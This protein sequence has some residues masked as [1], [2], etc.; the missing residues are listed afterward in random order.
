MQSDNLLANQSTNNFSKSGTNNNDNNQINNNKHHYHQLYSSPSKSQGN[1]VF[2]PTSNNF[3]FSNP[4]TPESKIAPNV[5]INT[6]HDLIT[7]SPTKPNKIKKVKICKGCSK[8]IIGTLVR[9][10]DNIYHVECFTCHDCGKPCSDKFFA[11]DIE[12]NDPLNN[13]NNNN[14]NK[15]KTINVPLCEYDYFRRI[16]LICYNCDKA[17][18]G[19]YITA[20][21]RKYHSDHFY[22]E[23]CHKVFESDNYYANEGKIYCHYHYSKLYAYHCQSCK[24]A[25]VKQYVEIYRGG[26]QQQW[27]PECFMVHKFWN[28]DVTVNSLG[29]NIESIEEISSNPEKLYK[30][31][32][33]LEK[34]TILI[35]STLSEFE[36]S[37]ASLI[38]EMLHSTT[39]NDKS[40]GLLV[41]SKLIFKIKCL[42]KSVEILFNY[43]LTNHLSLDYDSPKYHS[44]SKLTK[45]PRFLTSKIMSYL[46]FL[47]DT[48]SEKMS[49]NKYSQEL[50]SLIS[51]IAHFIKL[52]SKSS[53]MHALEFNKL[54]NS[55]RPTE[56]LL[57]EISKHENYS[58]EF[59]TLNVPP[60][61]Y[62]DYCS[63]CKKSIEEECIQMKI[64]NTTEKRWHIDCFNCSKC[65]NNQ[66]IPIGDLSEAGYNVKSNSILCPSCASGDVHALIG[67]QLISKYMQLAYL[68]EIALIRSKI[69]INKRKAKNHSKQLSESSIVNSLNSYDV[70]DKSTVKGNK[71]QDVNYDKSRS[72]NSDIDIYQN[73]VTEIARRRS[74]RESRQLSNANHEIRKSVIIEAPTAWSAGTENVNDTNIIEN[75]NKINNPKR[76]HEISRKGTMGSMK[77][78]VRNISNSSDRTKKSQRENKLNNLSRNQSMNSE[79]GTANATLTSKLLK[80]ESSLTLDDIP[81]IVNSEQAREHRPNAFRFQKRDY[82]SKI[83]NLPV[84]KS[85]S[86]K[87]LDDGSSSNNK[88]SLKE[89]SKLQQLQL[90]PQYETAPIKQKDVNA[91]KRGNI[92]NYNQMNHTIRYSDLNN[93]SHEYI[94]HIAAFALHN[95]LSDKM[96]LEDCISMIDVHKS[97]SFWEKLFGSNH[98]SN[99]NANSHSND[100]KSGSAT[101]SGTGKGVFGVALTTLVAKYGV[102]SDLGIGSTKIR[103]PLLIDEL[104][105]VMRNQ[106]VSAEGVFRLNGNI[107]RL[108]ALVEEIDKHPE[109]VPTFSTETPI[110][111]AALLKKFLRDLP[112]PLLTFKLYDLFLL[113]QKIDGDNPDSAKK[114][115]ILRLAYAM[116]PKSHRDLTEV[117]LAFLSW[118]ATFA[119]TNEEDDAGGSKMDTHNL[120]TVITPNILY[121]QVKLG[122]DNNST[123]AMLNSANGENQFLAIEVINEMIEMNEELSIIPN[124]LVKIYM[125]AGF[126]QTTGKD[127]EKDQTKNDD[128]SKEKSNNLLTKDILARLNNVVESNPGVLSKF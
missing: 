38:S 108:K 15:S 42:F 115:R 46:T 62:D 72:E 40:K 122:D 95:L 85:V 29:L 123:T 19:P 20:L 96:K 3:N 7:S 53:L 60:T 17:I 67:F 37:C 21:N 99:S 100:F 24:C 94:R 90:N 65:P 26:K 59:L 39:I 111:L 75:Q 127:K 30:V 69:V 6:S 71:I 76:G 34:L 104:I 98:N 52:I 121:A 54:S 116:L 18:R 73:K 92:S 61:K 113:S 68:L 9:A 47:R 124:D 12:V 97:L 82:S 23:I 79:N 13:N 118:V 109:K 16:D 25:I 41:T 83:S 22:C 32:V 70:T 44:Y 49:N 63:S 14:N 48:D 107:R 80:N 28:V 66:R 84:P 106:D 110:Q 45:E 112:I 10:M 4:N 103:I 56:I 50:L 35:W 57:S 74:L 119:N 87:E 89:Q 126:N 2:T 58:K 125:L 78:K 88:N 43:S 77:L 55:M 27:H 81:R 105:N 64:N 33:N 5:S 128:K 102:D 101:I 1:P 11:A 36:E 117:L 114:K 86:Y 51:T 120:A 31:E 91:T 93:K 8:P